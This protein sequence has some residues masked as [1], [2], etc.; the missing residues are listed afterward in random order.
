MKIAVKNDN[1]QKKFSLD[2]LA[3]DAPTGIY[4]FGQPHRFV[5]KCP[6]GIFHFST[7]SGNIE[8]F[9]YEAYRYDDVEFYLMPEG[10]SL[11]LAN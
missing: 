9:N 4:G 8:V 2:E 10:F 7:V 1:E 11:T 6:K 3:G 5:A